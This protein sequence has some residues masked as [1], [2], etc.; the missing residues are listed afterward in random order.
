MDRKRILLIGGFILLTILLGYTIYRVFFRAEPDAPISGIPTETSPGLFPDSGEG[1]PGSVILP[2]GTLP[3]SPGTPSA[4]TP[5]TASGAGGKEGAVE[6]V[7]SAIVGA[8]TGNGGGAQFYNQQDGKFYRVLP[9]GTI[10]LLSNQ[11]FYGVTNATWSPTANESIIE[12]PDGSNIY[13]NFDTNTQVTLPKHWETFS[14]APQGNA[15][16]AKSMGL[17]ADNRWLVVSDPRG[18]SVEL[19][20]PLGDNADKV[21][22][23]W[24]PNNQIVA[25]SRTGASLG[26][27]QQEVLF[28]G[29][30]G[31]NFPSTVVE[32]RDLKTAWSK[33][34]Q[35]LLYSVFSPASD[36]KPELW[37]VGGAGDTLGGGRKPLNLKTWANK[38]A[39]ADDRF[40]YCG[41]P[42]TLDSGAGFVP[43]LAAVTQD[44]LYKIDTVTG[45]KTQIPLNNF[46][47]I[48]TIFLSDDAKTLFF[49]DKNKTGLFQVAI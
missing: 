42:E 28:V 49:T 6:L 7:A 13:Y 1:T 15:I 31:E 32:G 19:I 43:D 26:A 14:F 30:N 27:Y 48:N 33:N 39:F 9:D 5:G 21:I 3:V 24:S 11:I 2:P 35:T 16:A 20:E 40:V 8:G 34:G 44:L 17:S 45:L 4:P 18:E 25:L 46:H 29:L 36:Y 23:D 22:V 41:V 38:C 47:T 10:A 37:V 12:Y